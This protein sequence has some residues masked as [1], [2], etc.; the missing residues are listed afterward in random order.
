[1]ETYNN[2]T[3]AV[4]GGSPGQDDPSGSRLKVV[5]HHQGWTR[6]SHKKNA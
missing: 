3:Y 6:P 2:G 4:V 1:M 5:Q